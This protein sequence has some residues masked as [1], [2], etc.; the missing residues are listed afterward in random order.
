M[1]AQRLRARRYGL[2]GASP[3]G[4]GSVQSPEP[5][6]SKIRAFMNPSP[7]LPL[8]IL[9]GCTLNAPAWAERADRQKPMNFEAET[10]RYDDAKQLS[11][12]SGNVVLTKGTIVM[13]AARIEMREDPDGYQH[14]LILGSPEAPAYFRQ[15]REGVDEYYEGESVRIEY[16]GRADTVKFL[17]KAVLRRLRGAVLA[18][19]MT[20]ALIEYNNLTEAL[21]VDGSSAKPAAVG[22]GRIRGM[23][24]PKAETPSGAQP[25]A[26][27]ASSAAPALRATTTLGG[28]SK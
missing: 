17:D 12:L 23:F 27:A 6:A 19:E 14:G 18:D 28:S 26:A 21:S 3:L 4:C 15:K 16:N 13:R 8:A 1:R 2:G 11:I 24:T 25:S 10:L 7:L 5:K 9:L 22:T 20:G